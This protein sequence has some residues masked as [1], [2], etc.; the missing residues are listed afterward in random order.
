MRARATPTSAVRATAAHTRS[1]RASAVHAFAMR[2]TGMRVI[3]VRTLAALPFTVLAGAVHG[4]AL[5]T[6]AV[7]D[8]DVRARLRQGGDERTGGSDA[9]QEGTE[10]RI[11]RRP[12][13]SCL[14]CTTRRA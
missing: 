11:E 9:D 6:A 5:P 1:L 7:R 12:G 2:A 10:G 8:T 14:D 4:V 13:L 3:G